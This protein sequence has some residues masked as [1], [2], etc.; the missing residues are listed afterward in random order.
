MQI[1]SLSEPQDAKYC[2]KSREVCRLSKCTPLSKEFLEASPRTSLTSE[3]GND[4]Q[5]A[6][7]V[8]GANMCTIQ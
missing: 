1:I 5:R 6:E 8:G 2:V 7:P 4:F 3:S